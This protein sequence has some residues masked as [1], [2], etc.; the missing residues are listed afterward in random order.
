MQDFNEGALNYFL[1]KK[2]DDKMLLA[3]VLDL[4]DSCWFDH[5]FI[6]QI[7]IIEKYFMDEDIT[8]LS[9]LNWEVLLDNK[10]QSE[11][12]LSR[13][14]EPIICKLIKEEKY[15]EVY[16]Y[17]HN[18]LDYE[19]STLKKLCIMFFKL[20][21]YE[22]CINVG[23]KFLVQNQDYY[24]CEI[25]AESY[26]VLN[27]LQDAN[28][29]F[30]L[31]LKL[32]ANLVS[33]KFKF[34][35]TSAQLGKVL[36]TKDI[37]DMKKIAIKRENA[38]WVRTTAHLLLEYQYYDDCIKLFN[39]LK[40]IQKQGLYSID[41]LSLA[42][43][44]KCLNDKKNY[45]CHLDEAI[46]GSFE[47][48]FHQSG[49][50]SDKLLVTFSSASGYVL[51]K[52]QYNA[53]RLNIIDGSYSYYLYS[54][55]FIVELITKLAKKYNYSHISLVG[56]S[57][58]SCGALSV[59]NSLRHKLKNT[60]INAVLFSGQMR[61]WPFN[62]NLKIPSYREFVKYLQINSYLRDQIAHKA[63][64]T[65]MNYSGDFYRIHAFYGKGFD[66]DVVETESLRGK[67]NVYVHPLDY[68]GH[69]SSI[70]LTIPEGKTYEDLKKA[71]SKLK[72]DDDFK[73]LGGEDLTDIVD[74]IYEIYKDP[75]MR[76]KN[77]L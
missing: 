36:S 44:Y 74:E 61:L 1:A 33:A 15:S 59:S 3:S 22:Q 10:F 5:E 30:E 24:I 73:A 52:Y 6:K 45:K 57:K 49:V 28:K 29:Y 11:F 14:F 25:V 72:V 39:I 71:Y 31:A 18:S 48:E 51:R 67:D 19:L 9:D 69:G 65:E 7:K 62:K 55:E 77:F 75:Q 13:G 35:M 64:F 63:D 68:S 26:L 66:M 58:G 60:S 70:P 42:N 38:S 17:I 43:A 34:L 47:F 76:L 23:S 54:S 20:K 40:R 56:L 21:K 2:N 4:S 8:H 37:A 12:E 50:D 41:N 16:N 53:D 27:E 46:N 32:N